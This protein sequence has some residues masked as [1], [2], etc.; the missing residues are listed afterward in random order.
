M[1]TKKHNF[2]PLNQWID[3]H[4]H[5]FDPKFSA[6]KI[7]PKMLYDAAIANGAQALINVG[8]DLKTSQIVLAHA[9]QFPACFPAVGIHPHEADN[10]TQATLDALEAL[11]IKHRNKIVAIGEIGLDFYYDF[12][13]QTKQEWLFKAQ[14]T[15][16]VKY[17]LPVLL[18]VRNAFQ[19]LKS[20]LPQ[21]PVRGISHCFGGDLTD[22][23]WLISRGFK[24]SLSGIL[25]FPSAKKLQ[26]VAATLP[27]DNLV[28]ETDAPYLAP[29]SYRGQI[30]Y[31]HYL[32]ETAKMLAALQKCSLK[33]VLQ[34]TTNNALKVLGLSQLFYD[35]KPE[36]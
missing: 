14:L 6:L 31:P 26:V 11:I 5:L 22:A 33:T 18:H 29:Q 21:F 10:V 9:T 34:I 36:F 23:Q 1:L 2:S 3:T 13:S 8:T 35:K 25:T 24:I 28:L 4:C 12:A 15:L 30:N 16:A 20:V 27:L 32:F 17:D 7:T 19:T